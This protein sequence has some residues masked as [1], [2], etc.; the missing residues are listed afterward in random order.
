MAGT[1]MLHV[2][3][4]LC[5]GNRE[6]EPHLVLHHKARR[7]LFEMESSKLLVIVHIRA[8]LRP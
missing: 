2:D 7:E 4:C 3:A 5:L 1:E 8:E 6:A